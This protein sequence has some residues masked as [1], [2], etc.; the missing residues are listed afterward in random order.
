MND[1]VGGVGGVTKSRY[2]E[3]NA[4]R[5]L[6]LARNGLDDGIFLK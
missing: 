1:W 3:Y 2:A 4:R 5:L 6:Y